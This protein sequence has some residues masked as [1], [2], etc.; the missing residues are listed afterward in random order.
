MVHSFIGDFR[1]VAIRFDWFVSSLTESQQ[2]RTF[3]RA[4]CDEESKSQ[5]LFVVQLEHAPEFAQ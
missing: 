2:G 5:R 4:D 3:D 1:F